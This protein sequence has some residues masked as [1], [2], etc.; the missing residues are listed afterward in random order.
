MEFDICFVSRAGRIAARW[1][2]ACGQKREEQKVH[3]IEGFW[4]K[5][6]EVQRRARL[7]GMGLWKDDQ[8]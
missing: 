2:V 8:Y 4:F 3:L 5:Q 6:L 1:N 7:G